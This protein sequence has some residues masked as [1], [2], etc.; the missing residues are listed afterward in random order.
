MLIE[1][2]NLR[3]RNGRR[4]A[5]LPVVEYLVLTQNL[6]L[7]QPQRIGCPGLDALEPSATDS[8]HANESVSKRAV[9]M[10]SSLQPR[11]PAG[12]RIRQEA[13][14]SNSKR[15]TQRKSKKVVTQ[16]DR[17]YRKNPL[18]ISERGFPRILV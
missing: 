16:L 18:Y 12:A 3:F 13:P 2:H 7:S 4:D 17:F 15:C 8:I 10:L 1:L 5:N 11:A 14:R 9:L 6:L